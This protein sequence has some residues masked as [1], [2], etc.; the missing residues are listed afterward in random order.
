MGFV[1]VHKAR[2]PAWQDVRPDDPEL[3]DAH[4]IAV[5][6]EGRFSQAVLRVFDQIAAST[7]LKDLRTNLADPNKSV[8]AVVDAMPW[9]NPAA[10]ESVGFWMQFSE[11]LERALIDVME[12]SGNATLKRQKIPMRFAVQKADPI[13]PNPFSVRWAR[14]NAA[15]GLENISTSG[16]KTVRQAIVRGIQTGESPAIIAEGIEGSIGLLPR[17][18]AAAQKLFQTQREAGVPIKQ[19]RKN[20]TEYKKQ[21]KRQRAKAIARTETIKAEARG[22]Q[23]AWQLA[24]EQGLMPENTM[25]MWV[26]LIESETI[27][28]ICEDLDGKTAPLNG[29]FDSIEGPMPAPPAHPS[30]RCTLTLEIP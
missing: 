4:K 22:I 11:T 10:P 20:V 17:Q 30:C 2:K 14:A 16:Q 25:Q 19:A 13:P 26:A 29:S 15:Q 12:D 6:H 7:L 24:N 21:L 27:C 1:A 9:Y 5:A 23:D 28:P 18:E 3:R 8:E